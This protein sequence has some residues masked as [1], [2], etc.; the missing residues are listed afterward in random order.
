MI[1]LL[2][3]E[4]VSEEEMANYYPRTDL[5]WQTRTNITTRTTTRKLKTEEFTEFNYDKDLL[6]SVNKMN[7]NLFNI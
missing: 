7:N 1:R 6:F 4:K 3:N 2:L 5:V